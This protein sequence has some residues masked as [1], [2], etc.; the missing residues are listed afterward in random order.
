MNTFIYFY[1]HIHICILFIYQYIYLK[2]NLTLV[3]FAPRSYR[4]GTDL[5]SVRLSAS[6][7]EQ[8]GCVMTAGLRSATEVNFIL[9][10]DKQEKGPGLGCTSC[11]SSPPFFYVA[12]L[13]HFRLF[14]VF[15]LFCFFTVS[16][17][18]KLNNIKKMIAYTN[19]QMYNIK[20]NYKDTSFKNKSDI[21]WI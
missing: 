11:F 13:L 1:V 21:T 19:V 17:L 8:M 14:F 4:K 16:T 6:T 15:S 10:K 9:L 20:N 18:C 7:L 12:P 3:G 2:Y 5:G